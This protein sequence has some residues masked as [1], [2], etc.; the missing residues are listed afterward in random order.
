MQGYLSGMAGGNIS[1]L[2]QA[3]LGDIA[4]ERE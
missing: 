1:L 3:R 4:L 2:N